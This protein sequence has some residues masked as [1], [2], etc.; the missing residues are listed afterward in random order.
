MPSPMRRATTRAQ[1]AMGRSRLL[2]GCKTLT[3][4]G[5]S[6]GMIWSDRQ[7]SRPRIR[8]QT[9]TGWPQGQN[10]L[11]LSHAMPG[12][13]KTNTSCASS[14]GAAP[15]GLRSSARHLTLYRTF[16]KYGIHLI[17]VSNACPR[18]SLATVSP[19]A[20]NTGSASTSPTTRSRIRICNNARLSGQHPRARPS[21]T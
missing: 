18:T 16:T 15:S 9:R 8:K 17:S 13:L 2:P 7:P 4:K 10:R 1:K 3:S 12:Q 6:S 5:V 19:G 14:G 20:P 21:S 11:K